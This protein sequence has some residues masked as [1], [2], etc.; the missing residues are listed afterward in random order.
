HSENEVVRY[1]YTEPSNQV[2]VKPLNTL[3]PLKKGV[4]A[5]KIINKA[6]KGETF[7]RHALRKK[8]YVSNP[9]YFRNRDM[10]NPTSFERVIKASTSSLV[11]PVKKVEEKKNILLAKIKTAEERHTAN[12]NVSWAKLSGEMKL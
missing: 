11:S 2:K 8:Y 9:S 5:I 4:K 10:A 3:S 6:H 12:C 7:L 1:F